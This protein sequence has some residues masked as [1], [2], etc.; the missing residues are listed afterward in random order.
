[1]KR[2]VALLLTVTF[3][4]AF[5]LGVVALTSSAHA[6]PPDTIVCIDGKLWVCEWVYIGSGQNIKLV[7]KCHWAGPC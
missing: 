3:V 1:M 4:A 6:D 7:Q 5:A 2:M